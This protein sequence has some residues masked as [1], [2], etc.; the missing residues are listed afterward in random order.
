[1]KILRQTEEKSYEVLK[2][3][4]VPNCYGMLQAKEAALNQCFRRLLAS[5]HSW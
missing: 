1:M 2:I 3:G 4:P 5:M